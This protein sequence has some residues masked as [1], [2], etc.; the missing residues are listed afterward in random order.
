MRTATI[1]LF[2]AL[3]L[4]ASQLCAADGL[5]VVTRMTIG[6][7]QVTKD[8]E[9]EKTRMRLRIVTDGKERQEGIFD[10]ATQVVRRISYDDGTFEELT[11][12]DIMQLADF[13]DQQRDQ[14]P[15]AQRTA[16]EAIMRTVTEG[17]TVGNDGGLTAA[18]SR[19][20]T[21]SARQTGTERVGEWTCSEYDLIDANQKIGEFCTLDPQTLGI[22]DADFELTRQLSDFYQRLVPLTADQWILKLLPMGSGNPP[23]FTGLIM[24][25]SLVSRAVSV[26]T[27]ITREAFTDS[28]FAVPAEIKRVPVD[29]SLLL[30]EGR[31]LQATPPRSARADLAGGGGAVDLTA[32]LQVEMISSGWANAPTANGQNRLVP[33][34]AVTL[35]NVSGQTLAL[36][37]VNAIFHRVT[38]AQEWGTAFLSV[39]GSGGLLAGNTSPP[40]TLKSNVGYT[41]TQPQ[42]QLLKNSRFVDAKVDLFAKYGTNRWTKIGEFS[43][44]RQLLTP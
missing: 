8:V 44:A 14:L 39:A 33:A 28:T 41:G 22:G 42:E 13:L 26:E 16:F 38:D 3:S 15:S 7:T 30:A 4:S 18:L 5:R 19:F 40:V 1:A 25:L 24:R 43:I 35:K 6:T 29:F 23:E 10:G 12:R 11:K 31:P 2:V 17:V 34:L 37:Q 32:G 27:T 21:L 9:L 36:L 20:T